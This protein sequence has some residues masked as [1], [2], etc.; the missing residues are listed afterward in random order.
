MEPNKKHTFEKDNG[1]KQIL[2]KFLP[3]WPLFVVTTLVSCTYF[4]FKLKYT[5]PIFETT[6]AILIKDEKKGEENS[7]M[8][9]VL[10]VLGSKKIVENE[11]EILRSNSLIDEVVKSLSL[12]AAVFRQS[13][14]K[15]MAVKPAFTLSPVI[16]EARDNLQIRQYPKTYYTFDEKA[17]TVTFNKN[18]YKYGQWIDLPS[19]TIRFVK[20]P[21]YTPDK[22][23][24][25]ENV[26]FYFTLSDI[27]SVSGSIISSLT[28]AP[29]NKQSSVI[30]LTIKDPV[31]QKAEVLIDEIVKAYNRSSVERKNQI[32]FKTLE[33]IEDRLKHV[34]RELDSVENG[35]QQYRD[36][37]GV[38]D[39][40]E[41]SK[42]ILQSI[43]E[44]DNQLTNVNMQLNTLN[45]V[46]NYLSS[47]S[48]Q[49]ASIAPATMTL[50]DQS[51]SN[52]LDKYYSTETQYEKMKNTYGENH[53]NVVSLRDELSK[54]KPAILENIRNQK[55]S[56]QSS[57]DLLS[58]TNNRYSS[59]LST[60]P[61]KEKE[62]VE[63][64]RQRNIKN[65]IY[66]FLLQKKEEISYSISSIIP[67]CY[68]VSNPTTTASPISPKKPFMAM[69]A[70]VLPMVVSV[71]VVLLKD[72]INHKILFR[73]DIEK[74]TDYPIVGELIYE[75]TDNPLVT[76][77]HNRSF[78][79]EQFR[80]IRTVLKHQG[81]PPGNVKRILVT[82]SV[83]GEGKSFVSGNLAMSY[84]RSG[85]K[86]ALLEM[87]L[88]QPKICAMYGLPETMGITQFLS[89]KA[90]AENIVL[91]SGKHDNLYILPAGY[92][93]DEDPSELLSNG[94]LEA[95]LNYLD[96][97]FD[98]III[99]SSPVK[100]LTDA[101]VIAAFTD[102]VLLV[103]RHN[104]TPNK[105]LE[106]L[107]EDMETQNIQNVAIVFNGVK[108]RGL[109]RYSYGYGY[110][111]GYDQKS[112][113]ND[114]YRK[115][116][117]KVS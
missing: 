71:S 81:T 27:R 80:Q 42:Q 13:G 93:D 20:N 78:I 62:L 88:H 6:A 35:I 17:Q 68:I 39:I 108:Q 64:S 76:D 48:G 33:F 30:N 98:L 43:G 114:Y 12:T 49:G 1:I 45:E 117:K 34:S 38:V 102:L 101:Y 82:S 67:D 72:L 4:Y 52:L 8:E 3:F 36:K 57:K 97:Q 44:S 23:E 59:M 22:E 85:K 75:K 90:K 111:Y 2:F 51:L 70:L 32:A 5:T 86:V 14:W 92:P 116:I 110:G 94:K 77:G 40:S 100:A 29:S 55:S 84:A 107:N 24:G 60:I 56:L 104:H 73:S 50:Q 87:D 95:L 83:K 11:Q 99:D 106:R 115:K 53:P 61:K 113:Y 109:G 46:E 18:T 58:K 25:N 69:L 41:Q 89:G 105:L 65:D 7:R 63:V 54:T 66:S 16:I 21:R 47:R 19:G 10:N 103:I 91:A 96:K 28:V 9:E 15:G 37:T 31:P 26:R 112:N 74:Y 79:V